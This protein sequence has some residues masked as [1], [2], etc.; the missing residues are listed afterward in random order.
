MPSVPWPLVGCLR[1]YKLSPRVHTPS[2]S[3]A[4]PLPRTK[5]LF[6]LLIIND[7]NN[8]LVIYLI[9]EII[10]FYSL[11]VESFCNGWFVN[12][13]ICLNLP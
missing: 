1:R 13:H 8:N 11:E 4:T 10:L 7:E 5:L 6:S 2:N 9:T 3:H 12:V